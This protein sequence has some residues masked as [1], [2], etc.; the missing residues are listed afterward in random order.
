MP[1]QTP[2]LEIFLKAREVQRVFF[3]SSTDNALEAQFLSFL[4]SFKSVEVRRG[5]LQSLWLSGDHTLQGNFF[6]FFFFFWKRVGGAL[7]IL[8]PSPTLQV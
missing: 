1:E 8:F 4:R 6:S 5:N 2:P 7:P 3:P